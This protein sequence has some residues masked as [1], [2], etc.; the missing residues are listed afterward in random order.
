MDA[1]RRQF[2]PLILNTFLRQGSI[3]CWKPLPLLDCRGTSKS[4]FGY[5]SVV[6]CSPS[7]I[8]FTA[9]V[10]DEISV[11]RGLVVQPQGG[12]ALTHTD[13]KS[14]THAS[15]LEVLLFQFLFSKSVICQL[16]NKSCPV[17]CCPHPSQITA[18][19]LISINLTELKGRALWTHT[20]TIDLLA[21]CS[22]NQNK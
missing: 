11:L 15:R 7:S 19:K 22:L 10:K 18:N 21:F 2:I 5:E 3:T 16:Y 13:S 1:S 6:M 9:D 8:L 4:K 14:N 20:Q 17:R 12:V